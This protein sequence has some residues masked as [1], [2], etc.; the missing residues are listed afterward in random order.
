MPIESACV[1]VVSMDVDPAHEDAFN[2]VYDNEHIPYLLGVPGVRAARRMKGEPFAM[3]LAGEVRQVPAPSPAYSAVYEIDG[4]EVL[5]S[6]EWREAVERGR[7]PQV[8][9][10]TTNR[11][12]A[13]YRVR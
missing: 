10:H 7:W 11:S 4:P 6:P 3:A 12:A 8:R 5:T 1:L 13:L 2:D 9:P